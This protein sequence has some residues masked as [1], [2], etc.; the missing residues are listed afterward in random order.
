MYTGSRV[1]RS[2]LN[3]EYLKFYFGCVYE[4][5]EWEE[6]VFWL[7]G[8]NDTY[9]VRTSEGMFILRVYRVGIG[10]NGVVYETALLNQL[11]E[12]LRGVATKVA[13]PVP[14]VRGTYFTTVD[15]PEGRRMAVMFRYIEG[16]ESGLQDEPSCY[17]F[18]QSAA[19]LHAAMDRISVVRPR[20]KLDTDFLINEPLECIVE[21][22]G[23]NHEQASFLTAFA[24]GL[25]ARIEAACGQG[26]DY[27][28]C[29]GD[30][31]GN[32]NAIVENGRFVHFDF[33]W[34]AAGWRAYDL[35]QVKGRKRQQPDNREKL[36]A[37]LLEGYRS[38]RPFSERDEQAIDLFFMA[39]RL[40]VMSL[41]VAFI[42]G[43]MGAIDYGEDWLN[44]FVEEFKAAALL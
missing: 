4:I 13:E 8:L 20:Y 41:D 40:W 30:M 25:K 42:P 43:D 23:R 31:H 2:V 11:K 18:G 26:L 35:A 32:N 44:G 29:H 36:W 37:A 9:R 3:A 10:E 15:A 28:I 39:R 38:V 14:T 33:E 19:E 1:M 17:A 7:R 5:G 6:C 27:G 21:Y 24:N 22:I 12:E 16:E 34:A